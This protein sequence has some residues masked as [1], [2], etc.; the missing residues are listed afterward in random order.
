MSLRDHLIDDI[1]NWHRFRSVQFAGL[2]AAFAAALTAY[3]AA[4]AIN[5][6]L[7]SG[8]PHWFLTACAIG[9][10]SSSG[11]SA[12]WRGIKQTNL[13]GGN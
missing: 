3:G 11:L 2:A 5:P 1:E 12:A 13:P 10:M 4:Y 6:I 7:V 9:S 8:I